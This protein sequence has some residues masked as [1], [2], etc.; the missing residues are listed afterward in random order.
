MSKYN[1][2]DFTLYLIEELKSEYNMSSNEA[3]SAIKNSATSKMLSKH[4]E[5]IM[6]YSIEDTANEIWREH[7][8]LLVLV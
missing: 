5:F 3:L 1:I 7:N 6:H 8:G 4:P 2:K